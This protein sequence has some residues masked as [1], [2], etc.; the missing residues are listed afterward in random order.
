MCLSDRE[1]SEFFETP[2]TFIS[3]PFQSGVIAKK[4][5]KSVF[6]GTPCILPKEYVEPKMIL[7]TKI[8]IEPKIFTLKILFQ[9]LSRDRAE[10]AARRPR[11]GRPL[12]PAR[13]RPDRPDLRL[14]RA[15][16]GH[17]ARHQE[18]RHGHH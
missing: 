16:R 9:D 14:W 11:A 8:C 4:P 3:N 17:D 15:G 2:S 6:F 10:L 18:A 5:L 12:G 7:Q 1:V 13:L